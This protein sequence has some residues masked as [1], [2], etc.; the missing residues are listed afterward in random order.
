MGRRETNKLQKMNS[1]KQVILILTCVL[2][3]CSTNVFCQQTHSSNL[4]K[5]NNKL[6]SKTTTTTITIKRDSVKGDS[7]T[8]KV[9]TIDSLPN[10]KS[11]IDR[12]YI[13][14]GGSTDAL[15]LSKISAAGQFSTVFI[16]DTTHSWSV[17]AGFNFSGNIKTE[18]ADSITISSIYFPGI[19]SSAF[20]YFKI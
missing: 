15:T 20:F 14:A 4:I 12:V 10:S 6:S 2:F 5:S 18:A 7:T 8:T 11:G 19:G 13:T 1:I 17:L 16:L 3:L 9:E